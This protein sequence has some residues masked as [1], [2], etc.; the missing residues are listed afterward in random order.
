[1]RTVFSTHF[2]VRCLFP[3]Y[4]YSALHVHGLFNSPAGLVRES[5]LMRGAPRR[6][7]WCS[8]LPGT[9]QTLGRTRTARALP[10]L[11]ALHPSCPRGP[12]A[13]EPHLPFPLHST[14]C[15][16]YAHMPLRSQELPAC[17]KC[18]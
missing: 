2:T 6:S 3:L 14:S 4:F 16:A 11:F 17:E 7:S 1:M 15:S 13:A 9:T 12:C 8:L 5:G 18:W 10:A